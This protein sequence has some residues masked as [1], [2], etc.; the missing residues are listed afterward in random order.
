MCK[1]ALSK[2]GYHIHKENT[3]YNQNWSYAMAKKIYVLEAQYFTLQTDSIQTPDHH[4]YYLTKGTAIILMTRQGLC[5][6]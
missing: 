4:Y 6:Y 5:G 2:V 1:P 3:H